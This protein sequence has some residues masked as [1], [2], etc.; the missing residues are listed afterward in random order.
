MKKI[1]VVLIAALVV[2][3]AFWMWKERRCERYRENNFERLVLGRT[4]SAGI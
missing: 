4:R 2:S 3:F 1:S